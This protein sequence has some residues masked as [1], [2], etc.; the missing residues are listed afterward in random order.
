[1]EHL[2]FKPFS[3]AFKEGGSVR[4]LV[5]TCKISRYLYRCGFA[6]GSNFQSMK[7]TSTAFS[8]HWMEGEL[9]VNGVLLQ[10]GW[11]YLRATN[12]QNSI[13]FRVRYQI[14]VVHAIKNRYYPLLMPQ[15]YTQ[16]IDIGTWSHCGFD[17]SSQWDFCLVAFGQLPTE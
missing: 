10:I 15:G 9:I 3:R 17:G 11:A 12:S 5:L 13:S 1:M 8:S 2:N 6:N 7:G 14:V 4:P 16:R